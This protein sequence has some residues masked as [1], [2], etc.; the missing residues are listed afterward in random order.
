MNSVYNDHLSAISNEWQELLAQNDFDCAL[1]V[2]G[3]SSYYYADDQ[4]PAFHANPHFLRWTAHD[5]CE[6]GALIVS[7]NSPPQLHWYTPDDYWYL[8]SS[9]PELLANSFDHQV[10]TTA[11]GLVNACKRGLQ[12]KQRIAFVG[13][14]PSP[15]LFHSNVEQAPAKFMDQLAYRRA[16][17]TPFEIENMAQASA[18][19][20][21]GHL[22][23]RDAFFNDAS[24][25][26]IHVAYLTASKQVDSQLPYPN[27]VGLNEHAS[28]LHYQHY[29]LASPSRTHSLLIDAGAKYR[30]YHADITRSYARDEGNEY[31]ELIRA[32]DS[33][34]QQLIHELKSFASFLNFHE[35]AHQLVAEALVDCNLVNC[36][37]SAA[38]DQEIT[39]IF[40]PHGTGHLLGLQTHDIGG[41]IVNEDGST[42]APP[43][44]FPS[45]RLLRNI[46]PN[47]A[48]TV[49]PG[50]Y[51]IP[52]LLSP[53]AGHPDINWKTVERLMP[54]GGVRIE[55][56]VVVGESGI[57][58][59][60]R[61]AFKEAE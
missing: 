58:N 27:I 59:L 22:A 43:K 8:P 7:A 57:R 55:D 9:I 54:F 20:V 5:E 49:E 47:M 40:Y 41:H 51:F 48:F 17:K 31:D 60:T 18:K 30:S 19:G 24:E 33:F 1:I 23:A 4:S 32:V 3:E 6:H 50:I 16:F 36:S 26:D 61:E 2:A 37:A 46:A 56:N 45:L 39:D 25:F 12:G 42:D 29:D 34:Q 44:R 14:A 38:Y 13:P 10:H 35:R 52:T 15:H 53:V 28:T 21:R 11:E